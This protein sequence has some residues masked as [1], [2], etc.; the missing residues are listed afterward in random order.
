MSIGL[1]ADSLYAAAGMFWDI[2]W[3]LVLGF[4]LS[5]I[6]M[7]FVPKTKMVKV[8]GR[9]GFKE[10]GFAA[11]FGSVSS[12][13]SYAAASMTRSLF[14]KGAHIIPALAFLL[15]S[16]NLVVEL[17]TVLWILMGWQFVVAEFLGGFILIFIMSLLMRSFGPLRSFEAKRQELVSSQHSTDGDEALADPRTLAGWRA[18]ARAFVSEW[19]MIWKDILLG[20]TISGFLMVWV[21]HSFWQSLFL[22]K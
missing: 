4:F 18:V 21:P 20:V 6:V 5:G 22:Q 13:C 15:A 9:P 10:L 16:T 7:V 3:A 1:I 17:T 12:S 19:R 11:F 2:F 8:L 14:Q